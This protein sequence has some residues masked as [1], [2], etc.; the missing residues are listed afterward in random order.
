MELSG[1]VAVDG[2]MGMDIRN[3]EGL[4]RYVLGQGSCKRVEGHK[5]KVKV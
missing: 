3:G 1:L 5:M 4:A 2:N